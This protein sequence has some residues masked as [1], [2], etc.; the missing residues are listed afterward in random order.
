MNNLQKYI[1]Y[2]STE[3]I[4]EFLDI[5]NVVAK[6]PCIKITRTTAY[7][8]AYSVCFYEDELIMLKLLLKDIKITEN[9]K[10]IFI[11]ITKYIGSQI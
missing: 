11:G 2:V 3:N 10:S 5:I 8:S 4:L 6:H 9:D 1:A 7:A